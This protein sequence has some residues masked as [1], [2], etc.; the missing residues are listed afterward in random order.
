MRLNDDEIRKLKYCFEQLRI[1]PTNSKDAIEFAYQKQFDLSHPDR[2]LSAEEQNDNHKKVHALYE[3]KEFC[4][5]YTYI[6]DLAQQISDFNIREYNKVL[7][8]KNFWARIRFIVSNLRTN[9]KEWINIKEE[10]AKLRIA[11]LG[12]KNR[13]KLPSPSENTKP[14]LFNRIKDILWIFPLIFIILLNQIYLLPLSYIIFNLLIFKIAL[15]HFFNSLQGRDKIYYEDKPITVNP[16]YFVPAGVLSIIIIAF[17]VYACKSINT[18]Y[19]NAKNY[20]AIFL[21]PVND[22]TKR[23]DRRTSKAETNTL[24][25]NKIE[26]EKVLNLEKNSNEI[27]NTPI[28][29]TTKFINALDGT[30]VK[31]EPQVSKETINILPHGTKISIE[32]K[33]DNS[34]FAYCVECKGYIL[35]NILS[36]SEP[37]KNKKYKLLKEKEGIFYY[38]VAYTISKEYYELSNNQVI[39]HKQGKRELGSYSIDGYSI[40]M[41]ING[42]NKNYQFL[43]KVES[44]N[45][46]WEI[47]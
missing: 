20:Q 15:I 45:K 27:N 40:K 4:L 22:T 3:C 34:D 30:F 19:Q 7:N 10:R 29:Q 36:D 37:I 23:N 13:A 21:S 5:R 47:K 44:R 31:D 16:I 41:E 43:G 25:V 46:F 14:S 26:N 11:D 12:F 17:A 28:L 39:F 18:F 42:M 2:G 38:Q 33:E 6:D 32:E 9:I 35:K 1:N 24:N 8:R